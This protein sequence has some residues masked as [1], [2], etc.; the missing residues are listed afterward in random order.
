M[1]AWNSTQIFSHH[2]WRH[3]RRVFTP[4]VCALEAK[5]R[6]RVRSAEARTSKPGE[7]AR[8]EF[9]GA[10]KALAVIS[11]I[12]VGQAHRLQGLTT[13]HHSAHRD[14]NDS[15]GDQERAYGEAD[16]EFLL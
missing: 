10:R 6:R 12:I 14:Q 11:W 9:G 13:H 16:A 4:A 1:G 15:R 3:M 8:D 2:R 5:F 7:S